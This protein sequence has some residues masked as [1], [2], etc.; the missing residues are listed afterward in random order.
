[1]EKSVAKK[2]YQKT[3]VIV[4]FLIFFWPVGIFLTWKFSTWTKNTKIAVSVAAVLF[5][6]FG[7]YAAATAPP[8]LELEGVTNGRIEATSESYTLTGQV[9]PSGATVTVNDKPAQ[10]NGNKFSYVVELKEGDNSVV[11]VAKNNDKTVSETIVIGRPSAEQLKAKEQEATQKAAEAAASAKSAA[12]QKAAEE[13]AK[14]QPKTSF[15]DGTYLVGT[16][17]VAGTYKTPGGASCYYARLK[18][19]SG[20]FNSILANNNTNGPAVV[21]IAATDGAFESTRCGTWSL[22]R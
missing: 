16:D 5:G 17:I 11:V 14:N 4:L 21:T 2:W 12:E 13:A 18:D 1:M 15:G 20:S 8:T 3:W 22:V 6:I 9:F 7:L 19:T 10:I